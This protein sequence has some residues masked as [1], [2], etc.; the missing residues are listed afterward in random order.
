M[1]RKILGHAPAV[2]TAALA[3]SVIT[4]FII[5][6]SMAKYTASG[7]VG[8]QARVAKWAPDVELGL[9]ANWNKTILM[10]SAADGTKI[11]STD[12]DWVAVNDI[13]APAAGHPLDQGFPR[14]ANNSAFTLQPTNA[15]SEVAAN[16]TYALKM[17]N[18]DPIVA[19]GDWLHVDLGPGAV[20]YSTN[21]TAHPLHDP[22]RNS[23]ILTLGPGSTTAAF[24]RVWIFANRS[25]RPASYPTSSYAQIKFVWTATQVD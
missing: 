19:N 20:N 25:S 7:A 17:A 21:N 14:N 16:F 9:A 23:A 15:G 3:L 12:S 5:P 10:R 22:A 4:L 11:L 2:V 8:A 6:L 18:G 1:K 24:Q 13:V